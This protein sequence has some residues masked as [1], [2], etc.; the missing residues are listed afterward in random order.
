[1]YEKLHRNS[2]L[3][4]LDPAND[5]VLPYKCDID[6][7][8]LITVDDVMKQFNI[9]PNGAMIYCMEFLE[10]N[11][12]WL[13]NQIQQCIQYNKKRKYKDISD[14]DIPPA[15]IVVDMPGQ[16]ELYTHNK[17]IY[18]IIHKN[19]E[20]WYNI[21]N[22]GIQWCCVN[23]CDSIHVS[24]IYK[25]LSLTLLSL[26][27][28]ICL[29]LSHINVLTKIDLLMKNNSNNDTVIQ[30]L[31]LYVECSD[32]QQLLD[33]SYNGK[34]HNSRYNKLTNSIVELL[35]DYSL[36]NYS[37]L[38]ITNTKTLLKLLKRIDQSNGY[39]WLDVY[40]TTD[41][42][43]YYRLLNTIQSNIH[44][45][46]N[47]QEYIELYDKYNVNEHYVEVEHNNNDNSSDNDDNELSNPLWRQ[48]Q[49]AQ[50]RAAEK[51]EYDRIIKQQ[52]QNT[53]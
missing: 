35:N 52:Q 6:I 14:K 34:Q 25:Y 41:Q 43:Q 20:L 5:N 15:Y 16:V 7:K 38:D 51:V 40:D 49:I 2:I 37:I 13:I 30:Q 27:T 3:I 33:M 46:N 36:V 26:N 17:S 24:D 47:I 45:D 19:N 53:K 31:Q 9:G 21:S 18:N 8:E 4:N 32:I 1:M 11:I 50:A 42:Q 39:V 48:E 22:G 10:H 12:S 23:L 29:E 28:M 44:I